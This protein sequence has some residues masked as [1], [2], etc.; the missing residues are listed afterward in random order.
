MGKKWFYG[1]EGIEFIWRGSQSDPLVKYKGHVFN[2]WDVEDG[3]FYIW[4]ESHSLEPVIEFEKWVPEN[5]EY[6]L[7]YMDDL[8]YAAK[9]VRQ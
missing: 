4:R 3:L 7:A 5:E 8:Y 1:V 2:Y 6:V 9:E